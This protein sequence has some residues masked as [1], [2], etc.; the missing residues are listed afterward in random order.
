[1]MRLTKRVRKKIHV[2][3]TILP[4]SKIKVE[5]MSKELTGTERGRS[6][7]M[8]VIIDF[9]NADIVN[10]KAWYDNSRKEKK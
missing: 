8:D 7:T 4:E 9:S 5:R 10:L 1:M 2:T 3:F 6:E